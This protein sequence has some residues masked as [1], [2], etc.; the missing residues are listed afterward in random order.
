MQNGKGSKRR[1]MMVSYD[2]F[3][4]NWERAFARPKINRKKKDPSHRSPKKAVA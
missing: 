3:S 2:E 4:K 1:P